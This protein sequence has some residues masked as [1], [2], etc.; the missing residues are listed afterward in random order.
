[1][2]HLYRHS[3]EPFASSF[4]DS[5]RT[6]PSGGRTLRSRLIPTI[7][8][9]HRPAPGDSASRVLPGS[10]NSIG[11]LAQE[12]FRGEGLLFV[13]KETRLR[14]CAQPLPEGNAPS[15]QPQPAEGPHPGRRHVAAGLGMHLLP[16]GVQ[17]TEG[18]Y[19]SALPSADPLVSACSTTGSA[20]TPARLRWRA[21]V[22]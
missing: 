10:P 19:R 21:R 4:I 20:A 5:Q 1:M 14:Q 11:I 6:A 8:Y 15:A 9:N 12:K 17:G 16:Q 3:S 7:W 22:P 13:R 2:G 18:F